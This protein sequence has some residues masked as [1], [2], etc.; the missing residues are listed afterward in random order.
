[1]TSLRLLI[2]G[3]VVAAM[4]Y[5]AALT[6]ALTGNLGSTTAIIVTIVGA[7]LLPIVIFVVR[8]RMWKPLAALEQGIK[9]VAEGDLSTQ[10]PV[11]S[12]YELGKVPTH[13]ITLPS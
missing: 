2:V 9:R 4:I 12:A 13:C 1:M 8:R 5:G 11:A 7:I 10:V 3:A 6:L